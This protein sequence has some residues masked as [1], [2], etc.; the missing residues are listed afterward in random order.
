MVGDYVGGLA[1]WKNWN[2]QIHLYW[3]LFNILR[4]DLVHASKGDPFPNLFEVDFPLIVL[5][6]L[7]EWFDF[8]IDEVSVKFQTVDLLIDLKI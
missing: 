8:A 4:D 2:T 5:V 1:S 7:A 3:L 6:L